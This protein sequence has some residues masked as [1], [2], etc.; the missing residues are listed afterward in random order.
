MTAAAS[1]ATFQAGTFAPA[2]GSVPL[3]RTVIRLSWLE[4]K[5]FVRNGEQ[6]VVNLAIPVAVL[7][8]LTHISV[9]LNEAHRLSVVVPGVMAAAIISSA[10]TGQSIAIAF[11]RRYGALKRI[12]ATVAPRW[13]IIV[14]KSNAVTAVIAAQ[15]SIIGAIG[16]V[17]GWSP[18]GGQLL[19]MAWV[20]VLGSVCF[21][22][23]G[24]F[25]GGSARA[26]LVLPLANVLWILQIGVCIAAI[27]MPA[28]TTLAALSKYTAA[29]ALAAGL[30]SAGSTAQ[31]E[32]AAVVLVIWAGVAG[33]FAR[34]FFR[35]T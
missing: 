7:L 14:T 3:I 1:N 11:D 24:I 15:L 13:A 8:A 27:A 35:F 22:T 5:L 32:F 30:T 29:G 2:P 23:M 18:T 9:G 10:F 28:T 25:L 6:L 16:L 31:A 33:Y 21:S 26:E 4:F 20:A 34:R 19:H 17:E 12:G